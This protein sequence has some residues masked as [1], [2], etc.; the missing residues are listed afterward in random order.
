MTR[1]RTSLHKRHNQVTGRA[2]DPA[3]ERLAMNVVP[4]CHRAGCKRTLGHHGGIHGG[5]AVRIGR[6]R[7]RR[8]QALRRAGSRILGLR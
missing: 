3:L 1:S 6:G 2:A 8:R 4:A 7:T 5:M